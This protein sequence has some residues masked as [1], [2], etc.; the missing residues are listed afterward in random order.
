MEAAGGSAAGPRVLAGRVD[1]RAW[2]CLQ[3]QRLEGHRLSTH[4]PMSRWPCLVGAVRAEIALAPESARTL[5]RYDVFSPLEEA[6]LRLSGTRATVLIA[7][8]LHLYYTINLSY[9]T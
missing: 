8:Q 9:K 7:A 4:R 5:Y 1:H 6:D 3:A 2:C